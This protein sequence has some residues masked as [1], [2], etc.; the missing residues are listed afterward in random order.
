MLGAVYAYPGA[1]LTDRLGQ[2]KS[3]L[4]FSLISIFGYLIVYIW[5]S[6]PCA[7]GRRSQSGHVRAPR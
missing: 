6:R 3:L 4:V 5:P 2:K 7:S 1:W